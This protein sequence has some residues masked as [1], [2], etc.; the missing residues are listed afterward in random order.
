MDVYGP[1]KFFAVVVS[2]PRS[3]APTALTGARLEERE[4]RVR[5]A[6]PE[7]SG[8]VRRLTNDVSFDET[9]SGR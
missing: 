3:A 2:A 4:E 7:R 6:S 5:E 1:R 8:I 9:S